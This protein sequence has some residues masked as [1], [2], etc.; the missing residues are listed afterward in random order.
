MANYIQYIPQI[1]TTTYP[2]SISN[3]FTALTSDITALEED[4]LN[5]SGGTLSG[6]LTLSSGNITID[7]G[8]LVVTAGTITI[9]SDTVAV[10]DAALT[11]TYIV[12]A[13]AS[14]RITTS[15]G[16]VAANIATLNSSNTYT[17]IPAFNGGISGSTSPFTVDST[18]VVVNLNSSLL[19]GNSSS[20]FAT[21]DHVHNTYDRASSILSGA[22]VFSNIVVTDGIVSGT[23]TRTLTI[24]N[25]GITATTTEVNYTTDVTSNIQAQ[26]NLKAPLASPIFTGNPSLPTGTTAITQTAGDNDTSIAT[27]AFVQTATI[28]KG[29]LVTRVGASTQLISDSIWTSFVFATEEYDTDGIWTSGASTRLTVP[30]GITKIRI[31]HG[32]ILNGVMSGTGGGYHGVRLRKNGSDF[33]GAAHQ[34]EVE[35]TSRPASLNITTP[36]INV[37][38]SNYFEVQ[39]YHNYGGLAS[40]TSGSDVWFAMEIIE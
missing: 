18:Q 34:Y 9:G 20:Y 2:V 32:F 3:C 16:I 7:T 30:S 26:L 13:D 33:E 15:S 5:L 38:S 36:I 6:S 14:G 27:T 39:F 35:S 25:L 22:N 19:E 28:F 8:N 4:K 31:S 29:A 1:N 12:S 10:K 21:A 37:T 17:G 40:I 11:D 23:A 24:A